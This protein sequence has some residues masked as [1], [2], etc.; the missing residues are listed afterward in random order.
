VDSSYLALVSDQALRT[1]IIVGIP[2]LGAPDW[3]GD[4]PGKP[5][6]SK[7]ISDVVAWLASQRAAFPG[8]P[9]LH[10]EKPAGEPQ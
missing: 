7:E 3:R 4:L 2:E 5:M 8:Q 6:S 1:T 10:S 9:Y